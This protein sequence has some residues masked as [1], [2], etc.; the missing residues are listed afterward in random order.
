MFSREWRC[1]WSSADRRCSKYI[2]VINNF[3]AYY[4]ATYNKDLAVVICGMTD[5]SFY[6]WYDIQIFLLYDAVLMRCSWWDVPNSSLYIQLHMCEL[7][8]YIVCYFVSRLYQWNVIFTKFSSFWQF[9]AWPVMQISSNWYIC[10]SQFLYELWR[11]HKWDG[12]LLDVLT[13]AWITESNCVWD[14]SLPPMFRWLVVFFL[15]V[16]CIISL[17]FKYKC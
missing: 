11:L 14:K 17:D 12:I 1:S 15:E 7:A 8:I 3:V 2:W 5:S 13:M 10:L 9:T 16:H 4:G 6:L